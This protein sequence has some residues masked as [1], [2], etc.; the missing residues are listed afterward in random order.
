MEIDNLECEK[1]ALDI[2]L[3]RRTQECVALQIACVKLEKMVEDL[4]KELAAM[5]ASH[6]QNNFIVEES[7]LMASICS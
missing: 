2:Q 6:A 4:K 5:K 7:P 3:V 1:I